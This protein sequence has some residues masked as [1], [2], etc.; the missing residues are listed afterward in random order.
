MRRLSHDVILVRIVD[1]DGIGDA[2]GEQVGRV[3][4]ELAA[5]QVVV[6]LEGA[7]RGQHLELGHLARHTYDGQVVDAVEPVVVQLEHVQVRGAALEEHDERVAVARQPVLAQVQVLHLH[8]DGHGQVDEIGVDETA[9]VQAQVLQR[10]SDER[11]QRA[12][13]ATQ[14]ESTRLLQPLTSRQEQQGII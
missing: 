8:V 12:Q 6:G 7:L 9:R 13:A 10:L 2:P 4:Q 5:Q 11:E 14:V 3:V 1:V